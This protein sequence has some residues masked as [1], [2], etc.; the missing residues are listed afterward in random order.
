LSLVLRHF[1]DI[2]RSRHLSGWLAAGEESAGDENLGVAQ[3]Q[4]E[5]FFRSVVGRPPPPDRTNLTVF[6]PENLSPGRVP[7][8]T[9][10]SGARLSVARHNGCVSVVSNSPPSVSICQSWLSVEKID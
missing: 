1:L 3:H 10:W 9:I 5:D 6:E 2:R 8:G 4:V 7:A